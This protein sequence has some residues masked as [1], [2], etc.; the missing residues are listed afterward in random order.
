MPGNKEVLEFAVKLNP[1]EA[2]KEARKLTASWKDLMALPKDFAKGSKK[3]MKEAANGLDDATESVS[4]FNRAMR[5]AMKNPFLDKGLSKH[6]FETRNINKEYSKHLK[7]MRALD[8]QQKV[9]N[10]SL[11][12]AKAS[13]DNANVAMFTKKIA[14]VSEKQQAALKNYHSIVQSSMKIS[15]ET[16]KAVAESAKILSEAK[17]SLEEYEQRAGK[18]ASEFRKDLMGYGGEEFGK[19]FVESIEGGVSSLFSKSA[20]GVVKSLFQGLGSGGKLL[21]GAATRM[22][23]K[24][25]IGGADAKNAGKMAQLMG[26]VGG[27]IGKVMQVLSKVGPL[28]GLATT[29]VM[30]LVKAF[31]DAEA[32]AKEFNKD[33]LTGASTA[34]FLA[35]SGGKSLVAF[36]D[37]Q[38]TM[39]QLRDSAFDFSTN[40]E[41]GITSKEHSA[42][43]STLTKEGVALAEVK[44]EAK[45]SN[46]SVGEFSKTLITSGVVYSRAFGVS[47]DDIGSLQAQMASDL[48]VSLKTAQDQFSEV[49]MA[50]ENSGIAANKFFGIVRNLSTDMSLFNLRIAEAAKLLKLVGKSMNAKQAEKFIQS[51]TGHFKGQSMEDRIRSTLVAGGAKKTASNLRGEYDSKVKGLTTE[52]AGKGIDPDAL[53][54]AIAKGG[55]DLTE[56]MA[57]NQD[58]LTGGMRSEILDAARQG[59]RLDSAGKGNLLDAA[60]ALK[61]AGPLGALKQVDSISKKFFKK[62]VEELSGMDLFAMTKLPGGVTEE[63]IDEISKFRKGMDQTRADMADKLATGKALTGDEQRLMDKLGIKGKGPEAAKEMMAAGDE[64]IWT[65]MSEDQQRI[66]QNGKQVTDYAKEQTSLTQT[67]TQ[68]MEILVDFLMNKYYN[69]VMDI[70]ELIVDL[71]PGGKERKEKIRQDVLSMGGGKG[72]M[73]ALTGG[74]AKVADLTAKHAAE[75]DPLKQAQLALDLSK[76]REDV[77][78]ATNK[79]LAGLTKDPEAAAKAVAASGIDT[80][81]GRT[82]AGSIGQD[83]GPMKAADI[84]G[85]TEEERTKVATAAMKTMN[86]KSLRS[87]TQEPTATTATATPGKT[88][89]LP[90]PAPEAQKTAEETAVAAQAGVEASEEISKNLRKDGVKLDPPTLKSKVGPQIEDSTLSAL[91]TALFEYYTY[92]DVPIQ[93]MAAAIQNGL[94]PKSVGDKLVSGMKAEGSTFDPRTTLMAPAN[95][96]GGTVLKP[97]PGEVLA[98]V[99]PGERIIPRGGGQ[100]GNVTVNVNMGDRS[101]GEIIEGK[102]KEGISIWERRKAVRA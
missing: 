78:A 80:M 76:A 81:K 26:S 68:K 88:P 59:K 48:G 10:A 14:E 11:K 92:K 32:Q 42:F 27:G 43:V 89:E 56:F 20:D 52:A 66:A 54:A 38:S 2:I 69:L 97:A 37:L 3:A 40:L 47:L 19:D 61:E 58:K 36:D 73:D 86:V 102:V 93:D 29:A 35:K 90:P 99:A 70:Y 57:K 28:I 45:R 22:Q 82:F 83:Q 96:S 51:L 79:A 101:L 31:I 77:N 1:K 46:Q 18:R 95:A 44:E 72:L 41:L 71:T 94:D 9:L 7:Q 87:I 62:G 91:R 49:T 39:R 33:I 13:G 98:S 64:A 85:L 15:D 24:Q 12:G 74:S 60:S 6:L 53:R 30:A 75:T 23:A 50:M 67:I 63:M 21:A 5:Q 100:G 25:A 34:E 55:K 8:K 84:A 65:A 17:D 4:D 16:K